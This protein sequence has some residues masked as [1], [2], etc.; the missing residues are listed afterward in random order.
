MR[1]RREELEA[2]SLG[3]DA[4]RE[5]IEAAVAALRKER[6]REYMREY[7]RQYQQTHAKQHCE[8]TKKYYAAHRD[9]VLE[10]QREHKEAHREEIREHQRQYRQRKKAQKAGGVPG[11]KKGRPRGEEP[12][13]RRRNQPERLKWHAPIIRGR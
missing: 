8:R 12:Q 11:A 2:I 6:R 9:E 4:T 5:E 3:P 7:N 13:G 10:Y 1:I